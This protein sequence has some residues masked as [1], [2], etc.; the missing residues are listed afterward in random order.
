MENIYYFVTDLKNYFNKEFNNDFWIDPKPSPYGNLLIKCHSNN[1][2]IIFKPL[3]STIP[4]GAKRI[5]DFISNTTTFKKNLIDNYVIVARNY[6]ENA[7]KLTKQ[8]KKLTLLSVDFDN[9]NIMLFGENNICPEVSKPI[10]EFSNLFSNT[11]NSVQKTEN[12]NQAENKP[13]DLINIERSHRENEDQLYF[14]CPNCSINISVPMK[15]RIYEELECLHCHGTFKNPIY[16]LNDHSEYNKKKVETKESNYWS[17]Y[18][19]K[20]PTFK[21]VLFVVFIY[22]FFYFIGL[23]SN[24]EPNTEYDKFIENRARLKMLKDKGLATEEDIKS[25]EDAYYESQR[26]KNKPK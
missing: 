16:S 21:Y 8:N 14:L 10:K 20:Y 1:K 13:P 3:D 22:L 4:V 19:K 26:N 12:I 2:N 5:N 18:N 23:F 24:K 15:Y 6:K 25:Y 7:I 9:R 17:E 11:K